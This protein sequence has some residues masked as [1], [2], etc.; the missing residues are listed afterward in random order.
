MPKFYTL[1]KT[2]KSFL[3]KKLIPILLLLF[4]SQIYAQ[5]L[6]PKEQ[7]RVTDEILNERLSSLLP[8]LMDKSDIDMWLVISREY[9]EDPVIK[10]ML[11]AEWFAARR[12]TILIFYRNKKENTLEKLAVARYDVG[13]IIKSAWNKSKFPNQWDAVVDIIKKRNPQK[14][15]LNYS[16]HFGIADGL[17]YNDYNA[18][19]RK[20]PKPY[21]KRIVSAQNLAISWIETRTK[22]EQTIYSQLVE[23]T[24][25]IIAEA[26]SRKVITPGITTTDDLVWWMRQKV[27][28][29]GLQTWFQP[30]IDIQ[31]SSIPQKYFIYS[32]AKRKK[33]QLILPGDL[34]HCD[35]GITYLRLNTDCQEHAYVLKPK[36]KSIPNYLANALKK[37]NQLQDIFTSNFKLGKTGNEILKKS[38]K[39]AK[40]QGLK[41]AIYTHPLGYYGHSAGPTIGMWDKQNGVPFNGDYPLN[42]N[43]IYAIELNTTVKI[44]EWQK[45]I[46]IMLEEDGL[47]NEKGFRYVNGRQTKIYAIPR[48]NKNIND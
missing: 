25:N 18:F 4:C 35:F 38:L 45:N 15:G 13:K 33:N 39:E 21:N 43:T 3:M 23:I 29:M 7:A 26:F 11:P 31:R 47:F 14:I 12:R 8:S 6:S 30:S 1:A 28:D 32:F 48:I 22:R 16:E 42:Y 20:L 17:T 19:T 41:P 2:T 5:I 36:E 37:G 27:S 10:T 46:R 44:S 24:H 40:S 9:N 34:L